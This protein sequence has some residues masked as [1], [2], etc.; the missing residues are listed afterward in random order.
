MGFRIRK[1]TIRY[2]NDGETNVSCWV[3]N[4]EYIAITRVKCPV[5]FIVRMNK[6]R[7]T[8]VVN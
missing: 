6:K 2:D 8:K 5:A 7:G 1:N 4:K 3:C